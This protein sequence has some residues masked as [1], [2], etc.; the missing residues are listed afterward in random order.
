M[1]HRDLLRFLGGRKKAALGS[2][3]LRLISAEEMLQ[4]HNEA[5]GLA[6]GREEAMGLCL[7]ACILAR[8]AEKDGKAVFR[9]GRDVLRS[10]HAERLEHWMQRYLQ[11]CREEGLSGGEAHW[12]QM[13]RSL[14]QDRSERAKWKVLRCFGILPSEDRARKMTEGDYLYC[15]MQMELDEEEY[16]DGLC[17]ACRERAES[18]R[19]FCCG[20]LM[21][22]INPAFDEERFEE[23]KQSDVCGTAAADTGNSGETTGTGGSGAE[24]HSYS[25]AGPGGGV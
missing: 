10:V 15:V 13:K 7:N 19:C 4:A 18:N 24:E 2:L 3:E 23:L 8:A 9:D 25:G 17:P 6:E 1:M 16:L 14:R 11:L 22:E 5:C 20:E 12:D 21:P